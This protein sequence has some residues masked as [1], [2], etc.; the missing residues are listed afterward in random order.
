M[1]I[2]KRGDNIKFKCLIIGIVSIIMITT[3]GMTYEQA[4]QQQAKV[5]DIAE[6]ARSIGLP[7]DN[8]IIKEASRLWWEAENTKEPPK[9]IVNEYNRDII[10]TVVYNE[11]GFGCSQ[12]HMELVAQVVVNRVN[13]NLFPNTVYD[14][15]V[16]RGQYLPAYA[17]ASSYYGQRA[18]Q[19]N[20]WKQCQDIATK[21]LTGQIDCPSNVLFQANFRQGHGTYEVCRTSYSTTYF[22]Y[23]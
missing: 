23:Y 16:Q 13:S 10:A 7:E 2:I 21:A 20:N 15:V 5:H 6:I 12:R 9:P 17:N 14:V 22:C 18:R 4:Q 3:M 8:P 11:A 1:E 19:A